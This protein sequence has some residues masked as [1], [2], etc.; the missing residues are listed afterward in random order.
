VKPV[1]E[2][3]SVAAA[4]ASAAAVPRRRGDG[5]SLAGAEPGEVP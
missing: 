5:I 1:V 3:G 4:S 2:R